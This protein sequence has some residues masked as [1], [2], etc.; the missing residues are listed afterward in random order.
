M[1]KPRLSLRIDLPNGAR[2]GP[3]KVML[4]ESVARLGSI[5]AA[6]REHDMSYRRAWLLIED[7]NK[8][9]AEPSVATFP[10]RA[11]GGGATLTPFGARLVK[12]Y[13]DGEHLTLEATRAV[14]AELQRL[15]A[16]RYQQGKLRRSGRPAHAV[17]AAS[18]PS[19]RRTRRS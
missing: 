18:R 19:A 2:L 10:G 3:G 7:L 13:R 17:G 9:F 8:A 14:V 11:Q 6:A 5:A 1:N 4:L 16:T 12:L 15:A